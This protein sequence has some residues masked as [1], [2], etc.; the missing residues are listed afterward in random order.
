MEIEVQQRNKRVLAN[1]RL[2]NN[3][4]V[5]DLKKQLHA[6]GTASSIQHVVRR[7]YPSRQA[8]T[9]TDEATK[10]EVRLKDESKT[11]ESYGIVY[12]LSSKA[13]G[14]RTS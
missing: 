8:Y 7:L 1:L 14:T 13:S 4:T 12:A 3:A 11:L 6:Q 5:A 10:K 2:E 9:F